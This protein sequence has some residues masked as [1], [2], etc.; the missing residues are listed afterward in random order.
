MAVDVTKLLIKAKEGIE[1]RN[2]ALAIHCYKQALTFQ[3]GN[4][5]ARVKLRATQSRKFAESGSGRL[6]AK[7]KALWPTVRAFILFRRKKYEQAIL[8]CEDALTAY[9]D[10]VPAMKLSAKSAAAL[11]WH[12]IAIW[13]R[14]DILARFEQKNIALM[15]EQVDGMRALGRTTEALDLCQR[16]LQIKPKAPLGPLMKDLAAD[17]TSVLYEKGATEGSHTIIKDERERQ[18]LE[19]DSQ[20]TRTDEMR[21]RKA[22]ALEEELKERLEDYR[23]LLRIGE[24]WYDLD[25]FEEGYARA[26]NAYDRAMS[27]MPTDHNIAVKMGDLEIKRLRREAQALKEAAEAAGASDTEARSKYMEAL[28]SLKRFQIQEYETRVRNQPLLTEYHQELGK[29]YQETRQYDKAVAE[30][31]FSCRDP[32]FSIDSYTRMG[33]CFLE[34]GQ[35]ESA[36]GTFQRAIEGQEVFSRIHDTVYLL[37]EALEKNGQLHEALE[38]YTRIFETDILYKDVRRHVER[39]RKELKG[40]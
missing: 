6:G 27:I 31:Q 1:R 34:M 26:K 19:D 8:S 33:Q 28:K 11:G 12:E 10:F 20:I 5:D 15:R 17:Q 22:E 18:G 35:P 29:L 37:A 7:L 24:I 2:Y 30:F 25:D 38:Q 32:R 16:I 39:L 21:R 13:Q 3:P 9:P 36:I 40:L 23:I 4:I 14:G